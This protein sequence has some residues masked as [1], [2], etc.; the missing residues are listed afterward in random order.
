MKVV[1][2]LWGFEQWLVNTE[3]YCAKCLNLFAGFQ[4]S[5]H[6]HPRKTE[7]FMALEGAVAIEVRH[8]LKDIEISVLAP[9]GGAVHIPPGT[10]HRFWALTPFARLLEISTHHDDDDV[11]RVYPSRI[12][13][14]A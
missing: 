7:T 9:V 4:S 14:K 1:K 11:V 6:F 2:K 3:L 5:L 10:S 13:E 12:L 8:S